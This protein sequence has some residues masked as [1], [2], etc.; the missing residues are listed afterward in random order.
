[1]M[2]WALRRQGP[3][4]PPLTLRGRRIYILPTRAGLA[5]GGLLAVAFIAG[6]NYGSGLAM[7][8]AFWLCGF[9][10]AA[11]MRTQRSMVGTRLLALRAESAFAGQPVP[12]VLRLASRTAPNDFTATTVD[13]ADL[14]AQGTGCDP[15]SPEN[16]ITLSFAPAQRGIWTMPA[17]L[18][19]TR[20]PFGL[21]RTWTWLAPPLQ[22]P[23][24]P[25][26]EGGR[27]MPEVPGSANGQA[28]GDAGYD[29]MTWLRPFREG[30]S[31][32]QV[33]WKAYARE[34]PLLVRE[35]RGNARM[36]REFG[37]E[38]LSGLPLERQLS[39]LCEWVLAADSRAERYRLRLP[40]GTDLDG[41]G[42]AHRD[43]CLVALARFEGGGS[44]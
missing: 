30:D 43:A 20:A 33:A 32:R 29:E 42:S 21:F 34:A 23:I 14:Q 3:D 25:R 16:E 44:R 31:P 15:P 4:Q 6:L 39:Q 9:A 13:G 8:L 40:G 36:A 12:V 35:Y 41:S 10:L 18:L 37:F 17:V 27:S 2:A 1:M 19:A 5:F 11:M 22:T 26:P 24:Y 38:S 28:S 7:L